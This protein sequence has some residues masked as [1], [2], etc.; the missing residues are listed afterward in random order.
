M[1]A[2]YVDVRPDSPTF[3]KYETFNFDND[4]LK[5]TH[6][7]IFIPA[8]IGNSVCVTGET[9][10]NYFYALDRYWEKGNEQGIAW[11]D[12]DL[13]IPWPVKNPIISERDRNNPNLCDLFPEKFL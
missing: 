12:P 2:A 6:K 10:V 1:F 8:G 9:P 11:D 7:A 5:S 3:G 13:N 4:D